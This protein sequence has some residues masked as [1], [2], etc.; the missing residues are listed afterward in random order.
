M[1]TLL[2][3]LAFPLPFV[4]T[5]CFSTQVQ[6]AKTLETVGVTAKL[7]LDSA[8]IL[9]RDGKISVETFQRIANIYDN[10][11]QPLFRLAL[12][13]VEGNISAPSPLELVSIASELSSI[14]YSK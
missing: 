10:K 9:L 5:G 11:F 14:L 2:F 13:R 8:A 12:A 7:T 4:T 6:Q 3:L 1:K